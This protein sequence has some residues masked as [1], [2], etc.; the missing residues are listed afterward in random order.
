MRSM[1]EDYTGRQ[2]DLEILQHIAIPSGASELSLTATRGE[3]RKVAGIQKAIQRYV[4]LLLN[5]DAGRMFHA[6]GGNDMVT[7]LVRGTVSNLGYMGHLFALAN[8]AVLDEMRRADYNTEVYGEVPADERIERVDLHGISLDRATSTI[9]LSLEFYTE[10]G[11]DYTY[12]V[13][14]GTGTH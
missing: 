4:H 6:D 11:S 5:P 14:I 3:S 2:V 8:A 1:S 13:P 9:S 7:A 10:A 12:I